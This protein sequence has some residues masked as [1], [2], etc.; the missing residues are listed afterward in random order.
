MNMYYA[1]QT[2]WCRIKINAEIKNPI[3]MR[4]TNT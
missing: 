3:I 2:M 4:P 1:K